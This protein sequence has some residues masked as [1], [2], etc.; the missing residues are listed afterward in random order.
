[1][2]IHSVTRKSGAEHFVVRYRDP[3]GVHRARAFGNR[4]EAERYQAEIDAAKARRR[5]RLLAADKD[6]F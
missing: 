4:S 5:E 1:M 2:S 6:R 3:E